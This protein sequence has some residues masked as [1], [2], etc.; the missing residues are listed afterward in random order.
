MTREFALEVEALS[1]QI[2]PLLAGKSAQVQGATLADLLAI[3]LAGHIIFNKQGKEDGKATG[4]LR[5][6]LVVAHMATVRRLV[7]LADEVR[8]EKER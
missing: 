5:D 1:E 2:K 8:R 3:Y 7:T 4:Q 6:E